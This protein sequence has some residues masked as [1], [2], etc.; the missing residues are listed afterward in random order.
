MTELERD[1]ERKLRLLVEKY[2]GKC[3]KWVCPGWVGVPDRIILL[4]GG[5]IHFVETKR[6]KGGRYSAVQDKWRDWLHGLGFSYR[7]I[8]DTE[9]LTLFE[10]VLIDEISRK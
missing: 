5:R 7:R 10:L 3:L 9:Q 2:G 8:K 6:P 4:P 1:I